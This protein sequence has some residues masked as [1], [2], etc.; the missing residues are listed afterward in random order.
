MMKNSSFHFRMLLISGFCLVTWL[1]YKQVPSLKAL[2]EQTTVSL[3]SRGEAAEPASP[4]TTPLAGGLKIATWNL[5]WLTEPGSEATLPPD[6]PHRTEKDISRLSHYATLLDADII[7][8]QEVASPDILRRLFPPDRYVIHLSGD[9]VAQRVG[10]AVRRGLMVTA[11]PDLSGLDV[12]GPHAAH[13]LRS[14]ADITVD[15]PASSGGGRLRLLAVH[16]KAGCR[17]DAFAKSLRP[18]C[19]TLQAQTIPLTGWI[20]ERK[21]EGVPFLILGD[22]NRWLHPGDD[23]LQ[24]MEQVAP[25]TLLTVNRRD[26]CHHGASFIDHILAGGVARSWIDPESLRVMTYG[27]ATTSKPEGQA[28]RYQ[29]PWTRMPPG[30]L[31]QPDSSDGLSDHCPVSIRLIPALPH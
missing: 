9:K 19:A 2:Y 17:R 3:V 21:Q 24:K 26:P 31:I 16:L 8:V 23:V 12:Y 28:M 1:F 27:P 7:A 30:K 29:L 25:L 11:N 13:H 14:G 15:L 5:D 6:A 20:A 4:V 22:F 18:A 10:F